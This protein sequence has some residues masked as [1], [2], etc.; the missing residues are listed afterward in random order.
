MRCWGTGPGVWG[1]VGQWDL[2]PQAQGH[3]GS[4]VTWRMQSPWLGRTLPWG[5]GRAAEQWH[6]VG[7]TWN[8]KGSSASPCPVCPLVPLSPSYPP[9]IPF[10]SHFSFCP[11]FSL[12]VVPAELVALPA[13][14]FVPFLLFLWHFWGSAACVLVPLMCVDAQ[15]WAGAVSPGLFFPSMAPLLQEGAGKMERGPPSTH[16]GGRKGMAEW[17]NAGQP[18]LQGDIGLSARPR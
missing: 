12:P 13:V 2:S 4:H 3:V 6:L 5:H 15:D 16:F 1:H 8:H 18:H 11:T 7:G 10:N 9:P 17:D 14:P